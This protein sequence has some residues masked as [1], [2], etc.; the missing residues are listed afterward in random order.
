MTDTAV[1]QKTRYCPGEKHIPISDAVCFGRRR[2]N[3]SKCPGCQFN[4][5]ERAASQRQRIIAHGLVVQE[6]STPMLDEV[7]KAYDV[8]GLYPVPLNEDLLGEIGVTGYGQ[9]QVTDDSGSDAINKDVH[10]RVFG[11]G[12]QAGLTFLPIRAALVFRYQHEFEAED[13]F[14]GDL[15][16]LTLMKSF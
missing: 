14:E 7:F 5:D 8:R 2:A 3:F 16:T 15:F 12:F 1:E 11:I 10:D 4:D 13:R 9:W 6:R